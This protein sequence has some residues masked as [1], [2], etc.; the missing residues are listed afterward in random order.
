MGAEFCPVFERL[1][2]AKFTKTS[3]LPVCLVNH[4][5]DPM[6]YLKIAVDTPFEVDRLD[7]S[8]SSVHQV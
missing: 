6:M 8:K 1:K 2:I 4:N 3:N 5:N 7:F